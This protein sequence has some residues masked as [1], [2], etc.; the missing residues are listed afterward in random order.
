MSKY[1][2]VRN[3][4]N[5]LV[6]DDTYKN[7]SLS[8]YY[9]NIPTRSAEAVSNTPFYYINR[10]DREKFRRIR[11]PCNPLLEIV[12]LRCN[13]GCAIGN[14]FFS[15]DYVEYDVIGKSIQSTDVDVYVFAYQN[16]AAERFGLMAYNE[17][18]TTVFNSNL[19][20]MN[21]IDF[22]NT[23]AWDDFRRQYN[24]PVVVAPVNLRIAY[25]AEFSLPGIVGIR[26]TAI[27]DMSNTGFTLGLK[28]VGVLIE[29]DP[30]IV[31]SA[32]NGD[33]SAYDWNNVLVID[34]SSL[35]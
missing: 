3:D 18:G 11:I 35:P 22:I 29:E 15:Q 8:R 32:N 13:N 9:K 25:E 10:W 30:P 34:A 6:I 19:K 7:L 4:R 14:V 2:E 1:L 17:E 28:E 31:E 33:F 5:T 21:V 27:K 23:P 12:A 20:Y 24:I 16:T 26:Y